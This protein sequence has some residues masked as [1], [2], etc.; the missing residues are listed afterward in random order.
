MAELFLSVL[1][2]SISASYGIL[3]V[4]ILRHLLKK[5]PKWITVAL[6]GVVALR[7]V[8]PLSLSSVFSLVPSAQVVK[9]DILIEPSPVIDTGFSAVNDAVN[10]ILQSTASVEYVDGTNLL[11][12]WI[13]GLF[14]GWIVGMAAMLLYLAISYL[15]L[16]K[17]M[18]SA[19]VMEKGVYQSERVDSPF[20][21]GIIKP[22]IYL[23]FTIGEEELSHVLA[24]ERAHIRRGDH[25]WKPLG[26]LLLT[27]HWFNPLL[28]V[29][30]ILLC[31][32]I[33]LAC[34]EKVIRELDRDARADYS[35]AILNC[36]MHRRAI[37]ACPLAFGE[38]GVKKRVKSV[39]SYKKPAFWVMIGALLACLIGVICFM[40]DPIGMGV[41]DFSMKE[42]E[43][44]ILELRLD[45]ALPQGTPYSVE[46]LTMN[47]GEY[48]DDGVVEY[49]GSMGKYRILIR[50]SGAE[51]APELK[52]MFPAY[53]IV[54]LGEAN[55]RAKLVYPNAEQGFALYLGFDSPVLIED[56]G[57]GKLS[58]I[59]GALKLAVKLLPNSVEEYADMQ[60]YDKMYQELLKNTPTY[61]AAV[62]DIDGDGTWEFCSVH[63]GIY[64]GTQRIYI[65]AREIGETGIRYMGW[66]Y[67][68]E[69]QLDDMCFETGTDGITRLKGIDRGTYPVEV[70]YW[71]IS[72]DRTEIVL[73]PIK[74]TVPGGHPNLPDLVPR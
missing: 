35:Q 1:N 64:S 36:S 44:D 70:Q 33:E 66:A 7:L 54:E 42:R 24:H 11:Q 40:T 60:Q 28:W 73:T 31:R 71:N 51:P 17:R 38:V 37:S 72:L 8:L 10:P 2:L 53:E 55:A 21:L 57:S 25:L 13:F 46:I 45:Y 34:D 63:P 14:C 27:I 32:D 23:P 9:P 39:L 16:H 62:L 18:A 29:G 69:L 61:D 26:Y 30:Y 3:A 12:W 5:A 15:R 6:W 47:Y 52:K 49:D 4:L 59:G 65:V 20:V 50:F 19:V 56:A 48:T 58:P 68:S 41:Y 74:G 67:I 43:A 22:R